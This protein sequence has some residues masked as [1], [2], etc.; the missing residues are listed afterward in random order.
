[1]RQASPAAG[2]IGRH[3]VATCVGQMV[4]CTS[5]PTRERHEFPGYAVTMLRPI[6]K[7]AVVRTRKLPHR[8]CHR[9]PAGEARD[10]CRR[11]GDK[12]DAGAEGLGDEMPDALI[13]LSEP[14]AGSRLQAGSRARHGS[15]RL[16]D[17]YAASSA[18][19]K[20]KTTDTPAPA[21]VKS[22]TPAPRVASTRKLTS[23][24]RKT[25]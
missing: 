9:V 16:S 12:S 17:P 10:D 25:K 1:M 6:D 18:S 13:T 3:R 20:P 19:R 21:S 11:N 14:Y 22:T 23:S 7:R 24:V 15:V 5:S 4:D 8:A 2:L